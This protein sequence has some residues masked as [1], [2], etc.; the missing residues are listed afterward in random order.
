[1]TLWTE[2]AAWDLIAIAASIIAGVFTYG[3]RQMLSSLFDTW[4][5][6]SGLVQGLLAVQGIWLGCVGVSIGLGGVHV[7][8]REA[9]TY[10][11]SAMVSVALQR[12]LER[13][14]RLPP[15]AEP[16]SNTSAMD[17][18]SLAERGGPRSPT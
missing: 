6:A 4:H 8:Q 10:I 15:K 11:I 14:G 18:R 5:T 2:Q 7:T 12:N 3:R 16:P 1:M 17:P 13:R 9:V